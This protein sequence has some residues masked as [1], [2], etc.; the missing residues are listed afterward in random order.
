MFKKKK[1][2]LMTVSRALIH[3]CFIFFFCFVIAF[4]IL[5]TLVDDNM[6]HLGISFLSQVYKLHEK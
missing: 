5:G 1:H 2:Y 6:N 4:D 3:W